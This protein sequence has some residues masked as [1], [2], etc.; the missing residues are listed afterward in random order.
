MNLLLFGIIVTHNNNIVFVWCC[1]IDIII[2]TILLSF[3]TAM[4]LLS[5]LTAMIESNSL[6]KSFQHQEE[7]MMSIL[8]H[9]TNAIL[10]LCV[11]IIPNSNKFIYCDCL[12]L[13]MVLV[14]LALKYPTRHGIVTSWDDMEKIWH[15]TF[16]MN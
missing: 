9:Q 5:F 13:I 4:I 8:Q 1:E 11:T 3:L 16:I 7:I 14:W 12:L 6:A 15:R 2:W 10:L